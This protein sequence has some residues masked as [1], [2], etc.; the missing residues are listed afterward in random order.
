MFITLFV[1]LWSAIAPHDRLTWWLEATPVFA[2]LFVL[3]FTCKK[4]PLTQISY[5][6]VTVHFIILLIGAHYTYARVPLFNGLMEMFNLSRN[7][8]DRVGHFMQGFVPAILAREIVVR[9]NVFRSKKWQFFFI[10][11]F[12]LALSSFYELFEWGTAITLGDSANDFLGT[13]GDIWDTQKDMFLALVGSFS[14]ILILSKIHDKEISL[15]QYKTTQ[16]YIPA[17]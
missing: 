3:F 2:G 11:C 8:Y 15:L 7:H 9:F 1:L 17:A 5:L 14:A 12:C 13:Q 6:L 4:F 10:I 16:N